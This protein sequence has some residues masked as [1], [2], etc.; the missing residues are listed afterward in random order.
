[1]FSFKGTV[2]I[3]S[4]NF[5]QKQRRVKSASPTR[6]QKLYASES[7]SPERAAFIP[8]FTISFWSLPMHI[9]NTKAR[10]EISTCQGCHRMVLCWTS[11]R[12]VSH[13][14]KL[15]VTQQ[16]RCINLARLDNTLSTW[17]TF[18]FES[19]EKIMMRCCSE[20]YCEACQ[21]LGARSQ[22]IWGHIFAKHS[23]ELSKQR[24]MQYGLHSSL[25]PCWAAENVPRASVSKIVRKKW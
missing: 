10:N 12:H 15:K 13:P 25:Y 7:Q 9:N 21:H 5:H 24:F 3:T 18:D 1:M 14:F 16:H 6:M 2:P 22:Q 19:K 17:M 20:I 23:F 4:F 8:T 11:F